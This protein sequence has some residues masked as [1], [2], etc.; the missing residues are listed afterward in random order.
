MIDLIVDIIKFVKQIET[1]VF[2]ST[3]F[4]R[5]YQKINS[6]VHVGLRNSEILQYDARRGGACSEL[7]SLGTDKSLFN[8]RADTG[9]RKRYSKESDI[10][11]PLTAVTS[12]R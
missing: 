2:H 11:K 5:N 3:L 10:R 12:W 6:Y 8:N 1:I 9:T 7:T 4:Q